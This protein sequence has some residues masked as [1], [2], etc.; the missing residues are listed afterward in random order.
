MDAGGTLDERFDGLELRPL[1][2]DLRL[3]VAS[4]KRSRML[5]LGKLDALPIGDGLLLKP[6][7]SIQ[8]VTMRF[9]LD[10]VWLDSDG[11]PFRLDEDVAPRR[12]RTCLRA[13]SVIETNAG[14]GRRFQA[15]LAKGAG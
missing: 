9:A 3:I 8:T 10:L 2:G 6:C 14:E 1:A 5:G 11:H 7:R 4:T 13:R 15:A 12:Q